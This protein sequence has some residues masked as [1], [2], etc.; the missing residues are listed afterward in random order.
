MDFTLSA[1]VEDIFLINVATAITATGNTLANVLVGNSY[2]NTLRGGAGD[3]TYFVDQTAD[4]IDELANEGIDLVNSTA[5]FILNANVENLTLIG[6]D[7]INGTGNTLDNTLTGGTGNNSLTGGGGNDTLGG[8]QGSDTLNGGAG[9]TSYIF[10]RDDAVDTIIDTGGADILNFVGANV[11]YTQLWFKHTGNDLEIDIIGT[12]DGIS[13][14]DAVFIKDWYLSDANKVEKINSGDSYT[15]NST[16]VERL[17]VA[18]STLTPPSFG[19]TGLP[20][21]TFDALELTFFAAWKP[22]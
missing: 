9:N 22:S 10:N 7:A 3:D 17:V 14:K 15:L 13:K 16:D 18:M 4:F 1:N 12:D 5:T 21:E 20:P 8:G 11:S 6:A 2:V 19:N